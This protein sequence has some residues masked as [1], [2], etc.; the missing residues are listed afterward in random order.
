MASNI[1]YHISDT[2][3]D[4]EIANDEIALSHRR[5]TKRTRNWILRGTYIKKLIYKKHNF[6][7]AF[8]FILTI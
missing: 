4:D 1:P 8:Y 2:K 5:R 6:Y 7:L 3:D